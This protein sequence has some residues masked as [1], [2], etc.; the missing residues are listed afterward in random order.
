MI[1]LRRSRHMRLVLF[2]AFLFVVASCESL[3]LFGKKT[4]STD[5]LSN[6]KTVNIDGLENVKGVNPPK[7]EQSSPTRSP[8][9][10]LPVPAATPK[11]TQTASTAAPR[12]PSYGT[13]P[14]MLQT[15]FKKKAVILDFEN[16]TTYQ[17]EKLGEAVAKK[18]AD[19]LDATQRLIVMDRAVISERLEKRGIQPGK[20]LPPAV[21]KQAYQSFGV[22][23]FVMGTVA[24][25]GLLSS[26]SSEASNEEVS[27]ATAKV[28]LRVIDA[29]T[30]NLL[31]TFIGRSPI[32]GT[33]ESG[34]NSRA[35][36]VEKAI[37]TSLDDV[38][39]GLLR[40]I[41]FL[42]WSSTIARVDGDNFYINA[43][44]LSGLRIGDT[45]E[46]FGPGKEIIHPTT[47]FSLGWTTGKMK[48]TLRVTDLFGVD[49]ASGKIVQ[50]Q[51]F[52]TD[53]VVKSAVR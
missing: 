50:G 2:T 12:M 52:A 20:V 48:G 15:G 9:A 29:S 37:E 7:A 41:D 43:G 4:S 17:D 47:N 40:Q 46:V 28:E 26:R 32:F 27:F 44:R 1:G 24:D 49:G 23:A 33:K 8:S 21:M 25:V 42:D 53:D 36:A 5:N 11:T 51:S 22:Q 3:P 19:R 6:A 39:D 14:S 31:K 35:K 10:P 18:L 45:L 16:Q 13:S 30:G 38:V 34:D